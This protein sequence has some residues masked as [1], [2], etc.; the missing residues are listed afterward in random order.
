MLLS[1]PAAPN[2]AVRVRRSPASASL[3][4]RR[5]EEKPLYRTVVSPS[6]SS[7]TAAAAWLHSMYI[8]LFHQFYRSLQPAAG[9]QIVVTVPAFCNKNASRRILPSA[10]DLTGRIFLSM[11]IPHGRH[12]GTGHLIQRQ[13]Q[14]AAA[15]FPVVY[16]AR[17][18]HIH[19]LFILFFLPGGKFLFRTRPCMNSHC[20][21][22]PYFRKSDDP[23]HR[24]IGVYV[25]KSDLLR[26]RPLS[27]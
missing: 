21:V 24:R 7:L 27:T 18:R 16:T 25:R 17:F 10:A 2:R 22:H 13:V 14:I 19:H 15:G 5:P 9:L 4:I 8:R 1:S 6:S 26:P 3:A 11:G 12:T 23:A 20:I